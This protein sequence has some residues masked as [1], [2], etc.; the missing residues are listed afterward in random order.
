[1]RLFLILL[2]FILLSSC[3]SKPNK[4]ESLTPEEIEESRQKADSKEIKN[5]DLIFQTSLSEQSQAIQIATNS[6]YSHCGILFQKDSSKDWY[7]IEAVQPVKWTPLKDWID[8][9]KDKHYV[10]KRLTTESPITDS[11]LNKVKLYAETFLGKDYDLTFEWS[12]DK[13]YCSELIWKTYKNTIGI[14]IG[15]TQKLKDFDLSNFIV[16][17]KIRER[18]GKNI[19]WEETV[20]SPQAIFES[21]NLMT[22]DSNSTLTD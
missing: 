15:T 13:I 16:S 20:I 7:V 11:T 8:R 14:E 1:M 4:R 18:Y 3:N 2:V 12:D 6:K 21:S 19:P 22:I 10:I 5:G 17:D 9:G